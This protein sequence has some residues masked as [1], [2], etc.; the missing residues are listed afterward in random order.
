LILLAAL[1][2]PAISA[3]APAAAPVQKV[4]ISDGWFRALPAGLPAGGYFTIHNGG[5]KDVS[6]TGA[7]SPACGMLMLHQSVNDGGMSVMA[8]VMSV[9]VPAGKSVSFSTG[10]YH[11]MCMDGKLKVGTQAPVS[12]RLSDGSTVTASFAVKD[13]KGK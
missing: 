10:G 5:T 8:M 4:T 6:I 13:A 2:T 1:A 3:P 12:L 9:P 7:R 11:L